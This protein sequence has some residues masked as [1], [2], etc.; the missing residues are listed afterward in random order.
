MINQFKDAQLADPFCARI[1]YKVHKL[2]HYRII[3]GLLF[4]KMAKSTKL[5]MPNSLLDI[6]INAKHF[7]VFGL[8]FS[9]TRI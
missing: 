3:K 2:K 6:I 1:M 4:F 8:H 5:V 9:K 7:L